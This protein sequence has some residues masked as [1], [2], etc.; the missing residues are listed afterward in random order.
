[1]NENANRGK[2]SRRTM[3]LLAAVF[4]APILLAVVW[5]ANIDQWRPAHTTNHGDLV[6][7]PKPIHG[8][9]VPLALGSGALSP[10]FFH[11]HWTLVYIGPSDCGADCRSA[12]YATRQIRIAVGR[13]IE[14]VQRLYIVDGK[15]EHPDQL[16]SAH[17]DLTVVDGSTQAGQQL[18]RQFDASGSAKPGKIYL[19]DPLGNLMMTYPSQADPEGMLADLKQLL[20]LS[21]IG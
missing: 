1:M 19:V 5:W 15:P 8:V 17:P 2:N 10:D 18:H 12:L 6:T 3:L 9:A 11:G 20:R 14:R 16:R 13:D 4:A 7:P 21:R